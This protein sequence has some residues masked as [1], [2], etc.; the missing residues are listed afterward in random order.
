MASRFHSPGPSPSEILRKN[1][2]AALTGVADERSLSV[3]RDVPGSHIAERCLLDPAVFPAVEE[4]R[5]AAVVFGDDG[6]ATT[7]LPRTVHTTADEREA[8]PQDAVS[9]PPVRLETIDDRIAVSHPQKDEFTV[10]GGIPDGALRPGELL[11]HLPIAVRAA[12]K[13]VRGA[14]P[15]SVGD[16]VIAA[17]RHRVTQSRSLTSIRS[18]QLDEAAA[19][20]NCVP[21]RQDDR[22]ESQEKARNRSSLRGFGIHGQLLSFR[23]QRSKTDRHP[24]S[25]RRVALGYRESVPHQGNPSLFLAHQDLRE[26]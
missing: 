16:E 4:V 15:R 12:T 24:E 20:G 8:R 7:Q 9:H 3:G 17:D 6:Y 11:H 18:E 10:E 13:D 14:H 19:L 2:C 21:H 23:Q 26:V 5:C 25:R 1:V 22:G